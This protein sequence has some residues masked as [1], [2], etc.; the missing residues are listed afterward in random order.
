MPL[1]VNGEP[2]GEVRSVASQG[3][4]TIGLALMR[5]R[6]AEIN[7]LEVNGKRFEVEP[8]PSS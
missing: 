3:E 4:A 7:H 8:L 2:A 1:E 5:S 6:H